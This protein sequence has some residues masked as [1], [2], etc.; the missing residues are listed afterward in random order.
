[1]MR[2]GC[3]GQAPSLQSGLHETIPSFTIE[4]DASNGQDHIREIAD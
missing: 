1:M 2:P 4:L 3:D